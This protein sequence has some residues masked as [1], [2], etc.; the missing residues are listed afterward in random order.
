MISMLCG[1]MVTLGI[2]KAVRATVAVES[3]VSFCKR[4][5]FISGVKVVMVSIRSSRVKIDIS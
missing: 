4:N 5:C 2:A 3:S 1:D